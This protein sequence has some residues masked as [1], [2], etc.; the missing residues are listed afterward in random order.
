VKI[1]DY[2]K[3]RRALEMS[4]ALVMPPNQEKDHAHEE[5]EIRPEDVQGLRSREE[6][7]EGQGE[8][9]STGEEG[10][11]GEVDDAYEQR[12]GM[13]GMLIDAPPTPEEWEAASRETGPGTMFNISLA[14]GARLDGQRPD[15]QL[16]AAAE[17]LL[18][19]KKP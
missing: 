17:A 14:P 10:A 13:Y 8:G 11:A 18:E 6:R 12:I 19:E 4:G 7:S 2:H 1:A 16:L 9:R 3:R 15:G 5:H